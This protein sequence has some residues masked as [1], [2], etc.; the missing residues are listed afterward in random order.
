M[1][2]K[3]TDKLINEFRLYLIR[4]EKAPSTIEKYIRDIRAFFEWSYGKNLTKETVLEYK[5]N[6]MTRFAPSST[7]SILS[8]VNH[9]F[10]FNKW[11]DLKVKSV[12]F[13]RRIFLEKDKELRKDEYQRLLQ[14]A[15]RKNNQQLNLLMQTICSC[16][17]RVSELKFITVEAL[18]RKTAIIKCKGKMRQIFLPATLCTLLKR[19]A[20]SKK[21]SSGAVFVTKTGNPLD[22]SNIWK[23]MK[24][25]CKDAGVSAGKVFPH[26]LRHLF[27]RTYYKIQKDIVRL[28]DILGHSSVN[29]TRIYTMESGD[30]CREQIQKLGLLRC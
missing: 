14:T 11:Y 10:E 23:M 13:Q 3:I 30:S 9:F 4:E 1:E 17:L 27:A 5:S 16:G 18:K 28:A 22:R 7:N 12:K 20:K 21:I 19:Y 26:N 2:R 25:L 6:I 24:K 8:S 15:K 29:T